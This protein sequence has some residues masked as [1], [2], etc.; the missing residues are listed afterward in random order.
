MRPMPELKIEVVRTED[1]LPYAGNAKIHTAEQI[2]QIAASIKEFG[3]N[4]PI[5]VWHNKDGEMEIVEGHGRLMAL[6]KLGIEEAPVIFL[7]HLSDAQRRAYTHIHNQLT[8]NTGFDTELLKEELERITEID[9][10]DMFGFVVGPEVSSEDW[11]GEETVEDGFDEEFENDTADGDGYADDDTFNCLF[12]Y[13]NGEEAA[14][15][16]AILGVTEL[17]PVYEIGELL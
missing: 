16:C 13:H 8:M 17:K 6:N 5:A 1:L 9:M 7:D 3:N 15:L 2:E 10:V 4:D 11:A 14:K 12:V